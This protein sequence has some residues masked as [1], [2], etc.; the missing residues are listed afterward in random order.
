FIEASDFFTIDVAEHIG[1]QA[2]QAEVEAFVARHSDLV[3]RI[4]LPGLDES[5]EMSR[6]AMRQT[7]AAYLVAVGEAGRIYHAI[8]ARKGRGRFVVEISMDE[9]AQPQKPEEL[10]VILAALAEAKIP[11]QTIAPKF[12]GRFN[13]GVDYVG[14][15][16][17]FGREFERDLAVLAWA[18]AR[19]GLP[20]SLKL[21]VHSGSD[22]FSLYPVIRECLRRHG[23]GL[24]LKTAGT[25]W[26]EEL[27]GLA[28]SGGD[29]LVFA[30]ELYRSA[31]ARIDELCGPY[32]SVIDIDRS[33]L[34]PPSVVDAWDGQQFAEALRHDQM[35]PRFNP[36]FRQLLHVAY[37]LAPEMGDR[38]LRLLARNAETVSRGV[39]V[40]I[41][42]KHLLPL[43]GPD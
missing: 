5:I 8:E 21:S 9:T 24:H 31:L 11:V 29:G 1:R 37:K 14:D 40:N 30:K 38:Y 3:G 17:G 22:K 39:T 34:P 36:H 20:P 28:L 12:S 41:L 6:E 18:V 26:L 2:P 10:L 25:T 13:K 7:A 42:E 16:A 19:F 4:Q 35:C 23:A 27:T 43:F 15:V 33:A 32:R